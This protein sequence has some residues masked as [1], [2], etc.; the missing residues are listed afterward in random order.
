MK[1]LLIT[2]IVM[3]LIIMSACKKDNQDSMTT[4]PQPKDPNTAAK[5][6]I[7]RFSSSA[8]TLFVR[9]ATNGLSRGKYAG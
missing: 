1:K 5:A 9:D 6:S 4:S 7:D 8:G 3:P 2:L